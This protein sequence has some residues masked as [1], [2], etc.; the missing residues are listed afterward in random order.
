MSDLK[1]AMAIAAAGMRAQSMRMRVI[2]ENMANAD[3]I[4]TEPNGDPYRRKIVTF[5]NTLDKAMGVNQ[6]KVDKLVTDSSDFGLKYDPGH[7]S[8]DETGY[9]RT[10]NVNG[11][12]ESIDMMQAQRSYEANLTSI[13]IAKRM[14]AQTLKVLES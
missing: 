6:V 11:L 9:I 4:A 7:P 3:S 1:G 8:A 5:K 10:P 12:L 13:E 2:A 14:M